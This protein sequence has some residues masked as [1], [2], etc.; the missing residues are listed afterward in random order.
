MQSVDVGNT[1]INPPSIGEILRFA[2]PLILGLMTNALM[3]LTDTVFMGWLGTAQLAAVP[4]ASGIFLIGWVLMVGLM[5]SS[6]AFIAR[7]YGAGDF[8]KIGHVLFHYQ[9]LAILGLPLLLL[10]VQLFPFF[11]ELAQLSDVVAAYADTYLSILVWETAFT[12][13]FILY[14]SFYQALGNSAFP[15]RISLI[16][17]AIN[18]VLDYA[19]I[20]GKFGLPALGVAGSAYATVLSQAIAVLIMSVTLFNSPMCRRFCLSIWQKVDFQLIKQILRIGIPQGLG[21][22]VELIAWVG[23]SVIAGRVGETALAANNIGM[24]FTLVLFLPGLALGIAA[25]SY[26]GRFLGENRPVLARL[27]T[28]KILW[29][30]CSYMGLLGIPLWF[31]GADI[32]RLFTDDAAVIA[33]AAAMF[34]VMAIYQ[35]FDCLGII[36]RTA[37][38]GAGDTFIPSILLV[39]CIVA[40]LFPA[41]ISLSTFIQPPLVGIWLGAF[42]YMIVLAGFM[43]YRYRSNRWMHIHLHPQAMTA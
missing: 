40:I 18:V 23:L 37:L 9:L 5:R 42:V 24:Q 30:G 10:Y 28:Y 29:I 11:S 41:A 2:L 38:S 35:L 21:D 27:T 14:A 22:F 36:T 8:T 1:G 3:T 13:L 26:M 32:A 20:F 19:L 15:M 25:A 12:L 7:L 43:L 39:L 34:K 4:F 6:I 33:E 16:T 17:L 31:F